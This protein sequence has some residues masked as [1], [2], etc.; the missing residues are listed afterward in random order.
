[1][2]HLISENELRYELKAEIE[3]SKVLSDKSVR[4]PQA[5]ARSRIAGTA[6]E[7]PKNA[8]VIRLYED[9]T[10][11]LVPN[12]KHQ[13]N[14]GPGADELIFKCIYTYSED[15]MSSTNSMQK[16][17]VYPASNVSLSLMILYRRGIHSANYLFR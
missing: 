13:T 11:L 5:A 1:M 3:R 10:D 9:L 7:D 8:Q 2:T 4:T 17:M 12:M 15:D 16:S 14:H 6:S